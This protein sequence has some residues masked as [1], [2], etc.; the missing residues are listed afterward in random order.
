MP[1]ARARLLLAST[2]LCKPW[3]ARLIES[4]AALTEIKRAYPAADTGRLRAL[5]RNVR[6]ERE[7]GKPPRAFRALFQELKR[8]IPAPDIGDPS[9]AG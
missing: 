5:A 7:T 8:L 4:D 9:H 6:I 3:R 1:A 2:M